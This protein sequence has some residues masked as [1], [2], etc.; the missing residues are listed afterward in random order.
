M[1]AKFKPLIIL[2]AV[3]ICSLI[4]G[5]A[6]GCAIGEETA[7]D[8]ADKRGLTCPVTY[9]IN[10][11]NFTLGQDVED[12]SY[13]T[14]YY[15]PNTPILNI[16]VVET[17]STPVIWLRRT[18]YLFLGWRYC[19]LDEDGNP[20]LTDMD[21]NSIKYL[22]NG[23][24]D[25]TET[26]SGRE[27]Q[28]P[29]SRKKFLATPDPDQPGYAFDNG[30]VVVKENQHLFLVADWIK[31]V[32]IQYI[33]DIGENN[34]MTIDLTK[35]ETTEE[36]ELNNGDVIETVSF[37]KSDS[38]TIDP[39]NAITYNALDGTVKVKSHSYISLYLEPNGVKPIIKGNENATFEKPEADLSKPEED[40]NIKIYAR[41]FEGTNWQGVRTVNE[42]AGMLRETGSNKYFIVNDIDCA[43]TNISPKGGA[44][45][46]HSIEGNGCTISN[47]KVG[48]QTPSNG[49]NVSLFGR[50]DAGAKIEDLTIENIEYERIN[51][52]GGRT[53]PL[54]VLFASVDT[55][56]TL[57]NFKVDG[58]VKVTVNRADKTDKQAVENIQEGDTPGQFTIVSSWLGS[59]DFSQTGFIEQYGGDNLTLELKID[60]YSVQ[61]D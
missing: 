36:V 7:Q 5:V 52:I 35:G 58:T 55:T 27:V 37:G 33:L 59:E 30:N 16:G 24:A 41:F 22:S 53:V 18:G 2:I 15:A 43:G 47:I 1:K 50:L 49:G 51:I 13:K 45:F 8:F 26:K 9:Y 40:R 46:R 19:L 32:E 12:Y 39:S 25:M 54:H 21:G 57:T 23:T 6:A 4:A 10:G 61:E 56:A 11:G 20:V 14:I 17:T 60:E 42:F 28:L 38:K 44:T 31:D 48:Q 34:K 29:E 3:F